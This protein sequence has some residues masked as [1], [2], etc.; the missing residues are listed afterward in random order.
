MKT[1]FT[2]TLL[3]LGCSLVSNT[4]SADIGKKGWNGSLGL[5]L[6]GVSGES[7]LDAYG[8]NKRIESL[9]EKPASYN[10]YFLFPE[11]QLSYTFQNNIT[12][13][14]DGDLLDGGEAGIRY[15]FSDETRL[16]VSI[17]LFLGTGGKVWQDPYLT[18]KDRKT[19]HAKLEAA[20]GFSV[21]NIW[22]SF[23]SIH[24]AYQ[25]LSITNDEAG[26]SLKSRLT[27]TGV[28]QLRRGNKSHSTSV[29]LPPLALGGGFN[30]V[31]G[32]NYV[33]TNALGD[34]NSFTARRVDL[35][36]AYEKGNFEIFAHLSVGEKNYR[37]VNPVFGNKRKDDLNSI[38]AGITY[39]K[40]F[41]WEN[42]SLELMLVSERNQSN[43]NFY[44][45][46]D[47]LLITSFNYHF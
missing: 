31:G 26:E 47:D 32:A 28:T 7:Q 14:M 42:S 19:T 45:T 30:L 15:T 2:T 12:T 6:G 17:P 40:P 22:G 37:I 21:D 20:I 27:S 44:D 38:A 16:S 33:S 18:R 39:W 24:Y 5:V 8:G 29:S 23:A 41:H 11:V 10:Y 3:T 9:T 34:A 25:D 35:T 46:R 13:Y 36:L 1:L 43:I 4:L